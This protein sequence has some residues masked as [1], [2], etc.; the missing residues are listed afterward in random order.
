LLGNE[1]SKP[2]IRVVEMTNKQIDK[3]AQE[4]RTSSYNSIN[5]SR[6]QSEIESI[7]STMNFES[8]QIGDM[9]AD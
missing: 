2:S 5:V 7:K 3:K 1:H 4:K 8:K 6:G 9:I